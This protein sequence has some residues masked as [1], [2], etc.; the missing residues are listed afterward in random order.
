MSRFI[1]SMQAAHRFL[2][3]RSLYAVILASVIACVLM[4]GRV[5]LFES[6]RYSFLV[7][8]LFLAWVPYLC[9]LWAAIAHIRAP[10]AW[11]RLL[12]PGVIWL[13]FFPN[14]PYIVT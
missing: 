4:I 10:G 13:V 6:W 2:A 12:L 1:N 5:Y 11:W 3:Q 7:W 8:N 14:A 9:C